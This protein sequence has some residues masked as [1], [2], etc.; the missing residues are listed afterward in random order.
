LSGGQFQD[1]NGWSSDKNRGDFFN[2]QLTVC[3]GAA[4][5]KKRGT[6]KFAGGNV[7][8]LLS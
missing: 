5:A 1:R 3:F 7:C 4:T 2:F 6:G 8:S